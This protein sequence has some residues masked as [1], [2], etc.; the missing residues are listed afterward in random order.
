M[1]TS[2]TRPGT[3][4]RANGIDIHYVEQGTGTPLV[5]LHGGFVSTGPT[6][7]GT[8]FSYIDHMDQLAEHFRVIALDT[9]GSGASVNDGT[10]STLSVL[11][12]D[13]AAV[14]DALGLERPYV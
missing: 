12:D 2:T 13:V 5:L 3:K 1:T 6:W 9:R 10:I 4:V 11:A 8:P 7:S 14:I